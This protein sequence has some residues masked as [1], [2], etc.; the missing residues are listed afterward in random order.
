[1]PTLLTKAIKFNFFWLQNMSVLVEL[2]H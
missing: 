2:A 1:M